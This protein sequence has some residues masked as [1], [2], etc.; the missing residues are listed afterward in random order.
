MP[1]AYVNIKKKKRICH[2]LLHSKLNYMRS[3]F[4]KKY[5]YLSHKY[6]LLERD[7][8]S[9]LEHL[10]GKVKMKCS[11][12][13]LVSPTTSN[14]VKLCSIRDNIVIC[15]TINNKDVCKFVNLL[16]TR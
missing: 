13:F 7:W 5:E 11:Y 10:I 1:M 8:Y 12:V 2:N 14:V 15:N 9:D 3:T 6:Q 4:S 16:W